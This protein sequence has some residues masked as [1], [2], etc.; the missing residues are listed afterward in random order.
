MAHILAYIGSADQSQFPVCVGAVEGSLVRMS[1]CR[2]RRRRLSVMH[3]LDAQTSAWG[4]FFLPSLLCARGWGSFVRHVWRDVL[5]WNHHQLRFLRRGEAVRWKPRR[6]AS[7]ALLRSQQSEH[8][9]RRSS[10]ANRQQLLQLAHLSLSPRLDRYL[11][12][13]EG[14][15]HGTWC[16]QWFWRTRNSYPSSGRILELWKIMAL[17][18]KIPR[19]FKNCSG[20]DLI[21][22]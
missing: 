6:G 15:L 14:T 16:Y 22:V 19:I 18:I 21:S 7:L 20:T 17:P 1:A 5:L 9:S 11:R 4:S 13:V 12:L 2:C 10:D 3:F 8:S